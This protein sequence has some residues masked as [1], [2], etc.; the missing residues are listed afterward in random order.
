MLRL[1]C[2][3][4][5]GLMFKKGVNSIS[6]LVNTLKSLQIQVYTYNFWHPIPLH[7]S[8]SNWPSNVN[9]W[10]SGS[11]ATSPR[12][13]GSFFDTVRRW[14]NQ[15][16]KVI[17][18]QQKLY[19]NFDQG[20]LFCRWIRNVCQVLL[21]DFRV[22]NLNSDWMNHTMCLCLWTSGWVEPLTL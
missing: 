9:T 21:E 15:Y 4:I 1:C 3:W 18:D 8:H 17:F 2:T 10:I 11:V 6:R 7:F 5:I 19:C 22:G 16:A 20:P 12:S 14:T 13:C